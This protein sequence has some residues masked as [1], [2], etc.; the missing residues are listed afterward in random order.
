M[1]I[2]LLTVA[3][4]S[5]NQIRRGEISFGSTSTSTETLVLGWAPLT[6]P[7]GRASPST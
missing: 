7:G 5:F 2:A 3:T 6:R 4:R 1:G